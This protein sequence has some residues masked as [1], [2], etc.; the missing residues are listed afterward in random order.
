MKRWVFADGDRRYGKMERMDVSAATTTKSPGWTIFELAVMMKV[1][2]PLAVGRSVN[3]HRA[4]STGIE[5]R[6]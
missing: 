4:M 2:T 1:L 3:F 5:P 6:W